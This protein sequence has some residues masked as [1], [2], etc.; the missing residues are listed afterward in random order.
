MTLTRGWLATL[1]L[2]A[3][4]AVLCAATVFTQ[5]ETVPIER[6][7]YTREQA[8][9]GKLSY[10]THCAECHG[11]DSSAARRSATACRH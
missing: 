6:G 2:A 10:A 11:S 1:W 7:V 5:S 4:A 9:R 8:E 3:S